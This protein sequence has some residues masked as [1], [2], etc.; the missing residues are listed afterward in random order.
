MPLTMQA[1]NYDKG[2]MEKGLGISPDQLGVSFHQT[3][4]QTGPGTSDYVLIP[5]HAS[6]VLCVLD[7]NSTVSK[8]QATVGSVNDIESN[9]A[10]WED[11]DHGE[12]TAKH[13]C[14]YGPVTAIRISVTSGATT[15]VAQ[16]RAPMM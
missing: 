5:D 1:F 14:I 3:V 6:Q 15:A 10:I 2:R 7:P 16:L 11:W 8:L 12:V 9:T 4:A 13:S